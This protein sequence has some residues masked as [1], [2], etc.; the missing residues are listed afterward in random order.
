M[1]AHKFTVYVRQDADET[2][3]S[4][5]PRMVEALAAFGFSCAV[6]WEELIPFGMED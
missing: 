4:V 1:A 5:T 6:A 2:A 3:S